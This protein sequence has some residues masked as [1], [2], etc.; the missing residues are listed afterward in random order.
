MA[1]NPKNRRPIGN[2]P[3]GA[4]RRAAVMLGYGRHE[5]MPPREDMVQRICAQTGWGGYDQAACK[6]IRKKQVKH[7]FLRFLKARGLMDPGEGVRTVDRPSAY[8]Y[9]VKQGH[10][11]GFYKIGASKDVDARLRQLQTGSPLPLKIVVRVPATNMKHALRM[12]REMHHKLRAYRL[13]GE[14]FS[15]RCVETMARIVDELQTGSY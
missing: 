10:G 11:S 2:I 4:Q 7:I 8:V 12:E 9:V 14:W 1:K 3:R 15:P 5:P 13:N 6:R